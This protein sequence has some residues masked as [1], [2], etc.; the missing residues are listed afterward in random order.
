MQRKSTT[1]LP[2]KTPYK[3]KIPKFKKQL[4]IFNPNIHSFKIYISMYI[5]VHIY[6]HLHIYI[7]IYL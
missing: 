3:H 7:H 2:K 5:H 6:L 1:F 4:Q